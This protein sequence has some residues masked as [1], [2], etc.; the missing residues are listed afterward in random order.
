M[1]NCAFLWPASP[2][3]AQTLAFSLQ[4]LQLA[5]LLYLHYVSS[6]ISIHSLELRNLLISQTPRTDANTKAEWTQPVLSY[7]LMGIVILEAAEAVFSST[8]V[9]VIFVKVG[10]RIFA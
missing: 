1:I 3:V 6:Q 5:L 7:A 10:I 8:D 2:P 9:L 4:Q